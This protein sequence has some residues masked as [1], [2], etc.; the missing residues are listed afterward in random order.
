MERNPRILILT[1]S[2]GDGHLQAARSLKAAFE[3]QETGLVHIMDLMKEAHPIINKITT[4]LYIKS[5]L[6]SQ[7]GFDYY[8]WSYYLTRDSNPYAGWNR[9][10]NAMGKKK[11]KQRVEQDRPD[12]IVCTFPFGAV[13]ELCEQE[14]IPAFTVVTDF[15]LHSRWIHPKIDKYYVATEDLREELVSRGISRR[16]VMVSGIPIRKAFEQT[17]DRE[18][19]SF[20]DLFDKNRKTI[21]ILAGSYG[22]LGSIEDM[23]QALIRN[24]GCQLAVVCGRNQKLEGKLRLKY[25]HE[26]HVR[27]FGFVEQMQDLMAVSSCIVTKAGGLTLSEAIAMQVPVFIF[28]PFAGQEKENAAYLSGKGAARIARSTEEL[29]GQIAQ[30]LAEETTGAQMRR[31]MAL[32]R[33]PSAAGLIVQDV[34]HYVKERASILI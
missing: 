8:G 12:A 19:N 2:Y 27:I 32:L 1:A 6:T 14:G 23:I 24:T 3:Q 26:P 22:V 13:P 25:G 29:A 20:A 10:F 9:Y 33:K 15:S 18:A 30:L 5:M 11:L 31:Q 7:F 16:N 17:T 28:K 34:L 4:T 21:L